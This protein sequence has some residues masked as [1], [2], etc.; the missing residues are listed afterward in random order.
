MARLNDLADS[1]INDPRYVAD[2][3]ARPDNLDARRSL[4]ERFSTGPPLNEWLLGVMDLAPGVRVLDIGCG[5]GDLW[6]SGWPVGLVLADRSAGMIS[7][8]QRSVGA[9]ALVADA[10]ALPFADGSFDVVVANWMLYHLPNLERGLTEIHRVL[11]TDGVLHAGLNGA[12]HMRQLDDM[13]R[14][15][16]F[17][18]ARQTGRTV[19]SLEAAPAAL[20]GLFTEVTIR[21]P[22]RRLE[23]TDAAAVGAYLRSHPQPIDDSEVVRVVSVVAREI[24]ARGVFVIDVDPG[25][26]TAVKS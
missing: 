21:R 25:L 20:R 16:A 11:T 4:H 5:P 13:V 6:E 1:H 26:V 19:L 9:P 10:Q 2:Q 18:E 22:E 23:V 12:R 17:G 7:A 8:A 14:Q 15:R 3:Y 24:E